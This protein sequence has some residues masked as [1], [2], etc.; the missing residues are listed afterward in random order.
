MKLYGAHM[1]ANPRRVKIYLAEKGL[2]IEQVD[3]EPPYREIRTA[4][5][6][7]KNPAGK[8]PVL[9]LDDGT[10][11]A[12]SAAII[13]YLEECHPEPNM[14]GTT[15]VERAQVRAL[16]RMGADLFL[17]LGT[18]VRHKS[19]TFLPSRGMPRHPELMDF[20]VPGIERGLNTLE[21]RIGDNPFLAGTQ[22]TIADCTLYALL[23]ACI[24]K[25]DYELAEQFQRLHRWY[26]RFSERPSASA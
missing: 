2:A 5:F 19:P 13:E 11:I 24:D 4:E 18:Y 3:F 17:P 7:A 22:P 21:L 12:E 15:P 10:C 25:F 23:H 26:A 8:I 16:E 1:A 14:L 20:F 6:L 9:E